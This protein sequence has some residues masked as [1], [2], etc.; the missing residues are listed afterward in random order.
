MRVPNSMKS[1]KGLLSKLI[2]V[3][4]I[5][6]AGVSLAACG[7][8][9]NDSGSTATTTAASDSSSAT[10]A[11]GTT[12]S[13]SS[14]SASSK[15][16]LVI[17][18]P[19]DSGGE[20]NGHITKGSNME[21]QHLV[22]ETLVV[23]EPGK[24]IQPHLA[25]SWDISEDGKEY[26]FHLRK[27]ISF[28]DGEPF[29]AEAVKANLDAIMD[30]KEGLKWLASVDHFVE[31]KVVDDSTVTVTMDA[32][33]YPL[34][35]EMA[36]IRPFVMMSPKSFIDGKTK[37][38]VSYFAGTGPYKW[39]ADGYKEAQQSVVTVNEDYWGEVPKIKTVTFKVMPSGQTTLQAFYNGEID[40]LYGSYETNLIDTDAIKDIEK[41]T[42][43][44]VKF[45]DPVS[46]NF[47]LTSSKPDKA[48]ADKNVRLAI[49]YAINREEMAESLCSGLDKPA[50]TFFSTN[51]QYCDVGLEERGYDVDKAK[52]LLE[53]S[54]Y[55]MGSSGY[56]E[57]D[58][59]QL[60]I[61]IAFKGSSAT[62]KMACEYLQS[63]LKD[64][65][66]NL[67]LAPCES[68]DYSNIRKSGDYEL[69]YE[70]TWGTDYDPHC[71]IAAFR[72]GSSYAAAV[73][74]HSFYDELFA[75]FD[76][77]VT[78]TD[79]TKRQG[80]WKDFLTQMHDECIAIPIKSP[81]LGLITTSDLQG[82]HFGISQYG[83]EVQ[84]FY[85]Q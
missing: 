85:Y 69:C 3:S 2:S 77:A 65:G 9:G 10:T 12:A 75:K 31:C 60:D 36:M 73:E 39:D 17:G 1:K 34:L 64:A 25:E 32:P 35:E 4:C 71:T 7:G 29:N 81:S 11:A 70:N 49:S 22:F 53:E 8:G 55:T 54:G 40:F 83:L 61:K 6:A 13:G 63:N 30:N 78:S 67:E 42:K 76:D 66:I 82:L 80:Y 27:G 52:S 56:Y 41:D 57:K 18:T 20:I 24:G 26:T 33:Y 23:N 58:G 48:T 59:K 47:L 68:S 45:S 44:Q 79:E 38:G 43:Y 5:A 74:N 15:D 21:L 14:S 72:K 50:Y 62:N 84:D 19:N 28:T 16:T 46:T 51:I 37:D